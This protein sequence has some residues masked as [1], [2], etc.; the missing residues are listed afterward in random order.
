MPSILATQKRV[1]AL[2]PIRVP[3][4]IP[5]GSNCQTMVNE[6]LLAVK[7]KYEVDCERSFKGRRTWCTFSA[8]KGEIVYQKWTLTTGYLISGDYICCVRSRSNCF[9]N[10]Q[11]RFKHA[12]VL[13]LFSFFFLATRCHQFSSKIFIH[14]HFTVQ[15]NQIY[16]FH[17]LETHTRSILFWSEWNI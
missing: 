1:A 9:S 11:A 7:F 2:Q 3:L 4:D 12:L 16:S 13:G 15:S 8:Q 14:T 6:T 10:R 17:E 5:W